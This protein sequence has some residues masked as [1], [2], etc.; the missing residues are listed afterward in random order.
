MG[1]GDA[2]TGGWG[3]G[4]ADRGGWGVGLKVLLK[5]STT[6]RLEH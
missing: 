4:D 1:V 3:V 5:Q 2:D 6:N